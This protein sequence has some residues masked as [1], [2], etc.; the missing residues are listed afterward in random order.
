MACEDGLRGKGGPR[1]WGQL[2]EERGPCSSGPPRDRQLG[3]PPA[4]RALGA[5]GA[6]GGVGTAKEEKGEGEE[7]L[8]SGVGG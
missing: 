2:S 3:V 8:E 6:P 4:A 7:S 5:P 1:G